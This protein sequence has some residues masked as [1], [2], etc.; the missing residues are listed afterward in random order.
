MAQ[1]AKRSPARV[2][3]NVL[4]VIDRDVLREAY[5]LTRKKSAP[6]VDRASAFS[7]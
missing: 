2:F 5:R 6:G 3:N 7:N 4:H 1:Q